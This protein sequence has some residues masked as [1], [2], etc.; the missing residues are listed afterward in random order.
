MVVLVAGQDLGWFCPGLPEPRREAAWRPEGKTSAC[1]T[2]RADFRLRDESADRGGAA[3]ERRSASLP[4]QLPIAA[5]TAGGMA[6]AGIDGASPSLRV[7]FIL[8]AS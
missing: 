2:W 3:C 8:A 7:Y 1:P 5:V 6:I 4:L